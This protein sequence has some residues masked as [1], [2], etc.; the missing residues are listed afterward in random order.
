MITRSQRVFL[1]LP[2]H[3]PHSI[4]NDPIAGGKHRQEISA[5]GFGRHLRSHV[6]GCGV[7][8]L[9]DALGVRGEE[10]LTE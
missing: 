9:A 6:I 4:V 1:Q 10:R 8:P 5:R 7:Q 2:A 3:F